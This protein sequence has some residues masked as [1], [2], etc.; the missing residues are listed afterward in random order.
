M[1]ILK[2]LTISVVVVLAAAL[3]AL[4]LAAHTLPCAACSAI[5]FWAT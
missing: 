2:V 3:N 1:N 4:A 5:L